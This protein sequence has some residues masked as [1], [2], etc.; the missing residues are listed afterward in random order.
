MKTIPTVPSGRLL[1]HAKEYTTEPLVFFQKYFS[2]YG[3]I[4]KFRVAHKKL[5][6]VNSPELVEK[7]LQEN[8]SGYRKSFSYRKM[9]A[10]LGEGL[11]TSEGEI[12]LK[13]RRLA[14]P[15]FHKDAINSY[16]NIF[17]RKAH[18]LVARWTVSAEAERNIDLASEMSAVT[19]EI[20]TEALMGIQEEKHAKV[21]EE[22]L[23]PVMKF[24]IEWIVKPL[25]LPLFIPINEHRN[26]K[27]SLR[28][29]NAVVREVI[30]DKMQQQE[31]S[32]DLLSI[33]TAA[34]DPASGKGI[35]KEQLNDEIMT[36]ILAGHETS[37]MALSWTFW[38]LSRNPD[39]EQKLREELGLI[40]SI[41]IENQKELVYT[42]AVIKEAM[43]STPPVW[44]T[45]REAIK[46]QMLGEYSLQK[47]DTVIFSQYLIQNHPEYWD[48]PEQFNPDRFLSQ[49]GNHHKFA[50]FPF[51]GGPRLCIGAAF[52]ILEMKTL[53]AVILK[54]FKLSFDKHQ[55]TGFSLSLTLR[56]E[57][58]MLISAKPVH[59]LEHQPF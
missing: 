2:L 17:S 6:A 42:E 38:H 22:H 9:K 27:R 57:H 24:M 29:L 39:I 51:G 44:I 30:H 36:F 7:I 55:K 41:S 26:F 43:R 25:S 23:P 12:W 8:H 56:P 54:S 52:A 48:K 11:F 34:T 33:L 5:I 37:A 14:Q 15:A 31:P 28:A 58:K 10:L 40:E 13:Q 18:E 49:Q 46:D 19:L 16:I 3:D 35:S 20:I 4:F 59:F 45:G 47:G 50:Y 21:I 53:L 1:G 32:N